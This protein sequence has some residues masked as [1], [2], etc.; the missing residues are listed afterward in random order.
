MSYTSTT[1]GQQKAPVVKRLIIEGN[2]ERA[3]DGKADGAALKVYLKVCAW[4]NCP[5]ES[6][7]SNAFCETDLNPCN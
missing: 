5:R 2:A 1:V 7:V 3:T 6:L 4:T